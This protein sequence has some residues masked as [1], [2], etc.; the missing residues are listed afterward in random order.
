[1]GTKAGHVKIIG[2]DGVE[3]M[4][5][6]N[7]AVASTVF[8]GFLKCGTAVLRATSDGF[9]EL[10][11]LVERKVVDTV[12]LPGVGITDVAIIPRSPYLLVGCDDGNCRIIHIKEDEYNNVGRNFEQTSVDNDA[13][14]AAQAPPAG[15]CRYI[16]LKMHV[17]PYK[18]MFVCS[19][20][21]IV[22]VRS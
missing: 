3:V 18:S 6:G 11:S 2:E 9:M 19:S 4:L 21:M 22:A 12:W 7:C 16:G 17:S 20:C 14:N 15:G 13:W 5:L 8:L 1:M 10:F